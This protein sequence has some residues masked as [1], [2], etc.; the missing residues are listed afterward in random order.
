MKKKIT[1]ILLVIIG[2]S[3]MV[4]GGVSFVI[5]KVNQQVENLLHIPLESIDLNTIQNGTYIGEISTIPIEVIVSVVIVNHQITEIEIIKHRSG[6]GQPAEAIIDIILL[7]QS[8]DVDL[9]SGST[10]SS[11]AILIAIHDALQGENDD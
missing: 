2:L 10:Y 4:F 1:M 5:H 3:I 6:Q 11:K 7:N 8:L 9:I